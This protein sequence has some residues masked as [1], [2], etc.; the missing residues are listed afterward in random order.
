MS[1]RYQY[2]QSKN[3]ALQALLLSLAG[4]LLTEHPDLDQYTSIR[5]F[6]AAN[7]VSQILT[8]HM[9]SLV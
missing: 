4:N 9:R 3:S 7:L 2:Q 6:T 8:L 5:D 1:A